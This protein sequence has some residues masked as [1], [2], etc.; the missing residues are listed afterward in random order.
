MDVVILGSG[1]FGREVAW[2]L[3]HP[4]A[5]VIDKDGASRVPV[6]VGFLDD[7]LTTHGQTRNG[8]SVLGGSEWILSHKDVGVLLGIGIPQVKQRVV[9]KLIEMGAQFPTFID[10]RATIG[11]EVRIGQGVVICAG[12]I[13]TC[14]IQIDD[15]AMVNLAVTIGHDVKIG[16]FVTLSPAVNLSGYTEIGE[17][18]DV[19]TDSTIIPGKKVGKNSVIGA[20]ACVTKDVPDNATAVGIP[21]KVIKISE[22]GI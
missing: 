20:M 17:G 8:F 22:P 1:G 15:F 13:A 11:D 16:R 9:P 6:L 21:A 3:S 4:D 19:G 5:R 10:P 14:N 12:A 2:A 18:T 7:D